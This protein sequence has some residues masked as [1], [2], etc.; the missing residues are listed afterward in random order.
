MALACTVSQTFDLSSTQ[1]YSLLLQSAHGTVPLKVLDIILL[2]GGS[3]SV[4]LFTDT[5]G[6]F[7]SKSLS[8][9]GIDELIK[10]IISNIDGGDK[11]VSHGDVLVLLN[12]STIRIY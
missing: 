12:R 7:N 5:K 8:E 10:A 4:W 9:M 11:K 6:N 2:T 3:P 1:F